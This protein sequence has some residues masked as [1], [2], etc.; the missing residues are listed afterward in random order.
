MP[1]GVGVT[2]GMGMAGVTPQLTRDRGSPLYHQIYLVIR[3]AIGSGRYQPGEMLPTEDALAAQFGVSRIT[4]RRAMDALERARLIDRR[5]GRGTFVRDS[6][7][8]TLTVPLASVASQILRVGETTEA[9]VL[10]FDY[11]VPPPEV[12]ELFALGPGETLQRAVRVRLRDGT[13]VFHLT[14]FVCDRVARTFDRAS[15]ERTALFELIRR[16]GVTVAHGEQ[17]VT[18]TL[19]DPLVAQRL[20]V[21]IGAP[22]L[23]VLRVLRDE[24][25]RPVEHL[26]MVCSPDRFQLHYAIERDDI[27]SIHA[28]MGSGQIIA[29]PIAAR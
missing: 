17:V 22:L 12:R 1:T 16:A 7:R 21:K 13:P 8:P 2:N 11:V 9:R 18:A 20:D 23:R 28:R 10:E 15:M 29:G 14:T 6:G 27:R 4:I 25:D 5:Q 24:G 26:D 3:E 19:A